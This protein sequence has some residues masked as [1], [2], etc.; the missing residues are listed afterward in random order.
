M[1]GLAVAAVGVVAVVSVVNLGVLGTGGPGPALAPA[2]VGAALAACGLLL[3]LERS[4]G[5]TGAI[6]I[7]PV[8]AAFGGLV[9]AALLVDVVGLALTVG[10]LTAWCA[11][12]V[13]RA[14]LGRAVPLA[15]VIAVATELLGGALAR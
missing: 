15:V 13:T 12:A 4:P 3:L 1:L 10:L 14:P 2:I 6:R 11:L 8:I 5:S 9:G 7:P